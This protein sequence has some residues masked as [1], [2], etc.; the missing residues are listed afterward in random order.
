MKDEI[1]PELVLEY[2]TGS[3]GNINP[4]WNQALA[5]YP[6]VYDFGGQLQKAMLNMVQSVDVFRTYD[7]SPLLMT[8]T[9][10]RR[11][12]DILKQ[13]Q[14]QP[15]YRAV[16]N[17]Q[18][19]CNVSVGLGVLVASKRHPNMGERTY[20]GKDLHHQLSGPRLMQKRMDEVAR[21]GRWARIAPAFPAGE[22][23]YLSSENELIDQCEYTP[24]DTWARHT[25]GK[26]VSQSAPAIM[27]RNMPLP[28]VETQGAYAPF[29]CASTYPNGATGIAAEGRVSPE[30]RWFEPRA[31]VTVQIKDASKPIG[32]VGRYEELVLEFA[33]DLDQV[34][35]IWAQDLLADKSEDIKSLVKTQG[36]SL[37]ISGELIDR[38]GL[39]AGSEG[40][41]SVPGLVIRLEGENLPVAGTE[42]T[43]VVAIPTA[44]EK[45]RVPVKKQSVDGFSG[46]AS[47]EK[48]PFGYEL[49]STAQNPGFSLKKLS[50]P[51]TSGKATITWKMKDA[52]AKAATRNGFLVLSSDDDA[53]ASVFAGAWTGSGKLSSFESVGAFQKDKQAKFNPSPVMDCKLELDMDARRV[54]LTIN[55]KKLENSLTESVTGIN[56]IGFATRQATTQFSEPVIER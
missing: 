27:A 14:Q 22:G 35:H 31:K 36:A 38:I 9:T 28:V 37:V 41:L 42:F 49:S 50:Q 12:H 15:K 54:V 1:Y 17:V 40:D 44:A 30:N 18:D 20:K 19:D 39:S 26:M 51:I 33:E 25:Y 32:V 2:I 5:S 55:G 10:L 56:Y 7:A 53:L 23:T 34:Q 16:L 24:W 45:P 11:T 48:V 13:T 6:S 4:K 47:I 3:G 43:P 46:T 52:D 29:V 21:F 8:S